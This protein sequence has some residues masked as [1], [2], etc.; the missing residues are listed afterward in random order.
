MIPIHK[1]YRLVI[2]GRYERLFLTKYEGEGLILSIVF[3]QTTQGY[4]VFK[5]H[6]YCLR[7]A[8]P[9]S[10]RVTL[11]MKHV[12]KYCLLNVADVATGDVRNEYSCEIVLIVRE[13]HVLQ[14]III[15]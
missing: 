6:K 11:S 9:V 2:G 8:V 10:Q 7:L 14:I 1:I 12:P 3:L 13:F 15:T 5:A 4:Y